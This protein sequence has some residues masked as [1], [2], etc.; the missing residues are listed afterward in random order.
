MKKNLQNFIFQ[1]LQYTFILAQEIFSYRMQIL[2]DFSEKSM[3]EKWIIYLKVVAHFVARNISTII[4]KW[5]ERILKYW[6]RYAWC[7]QYVGRSF[8]KYGR[9]YWSS[10]F[11]VFDTFKHI[12]TQFH[13][14]FTISHFLH[15]FTLFTKFHTFDT[16]SLSLSSATSCLSLGS[17]SLAGATVGGGVLKYSA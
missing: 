16:I 11:T 1:E 3:N 10:L 9:E 17:T 15:N 5:N 13:T 7:P 6:V 4:S 14:S 12:S 2:V 8:S